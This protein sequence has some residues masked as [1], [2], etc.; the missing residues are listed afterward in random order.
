VGKVKLNWGR[1]RGLARS[2]GSRSCGWRR[3]AAAIAALALIPIAHPAQ[4]QVPCA[5]PAAGEFLL[6]VRRG[7]RA[8]EERLYDALPTGVSLDACDYVGEAVWRLSGFPSR[9]IADAWIEYLRDRAAL[10]AYPIEAGS[11]PPPFEPQAYR[12]PYAVLVDYGD[13]PN[14]AIAVAQFLQ[15]PLDLVSFGQRPYLLVGGGRDVRQA[16]DLIQQLSDR[17]FAA[18]IADGRQVIVLR[19]PVPLP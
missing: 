19:S 5:P 7:D 8:A 10:E 18:L 4:A 2:H 9:A 14:V 15:R 11:A 12:E 1:S 16:G 6:L 3:V 13:D 17:G